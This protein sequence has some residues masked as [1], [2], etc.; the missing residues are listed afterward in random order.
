MLAT[1]VYM[2]VFR[3]VHILAGVLWVGGLGLF[4]LYLQPAAKALGP[5][6]GPFL[7]ELVAKR[8]LPNYLL[9]AGAFTIVAG[10]FLYWHDWQ[11]AASLGDWLDLTV[12]KILTV[13]ALAALIA[14]LMGLLLLKPPV[15]RMM[16]LGGQIAASGG[17]PSPEQGA[18]LQSLQLKSRRLSIAVLALLVFSVLAMSTARY[19]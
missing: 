7:Q 17:P 19:W 12:G 18:E 2:I 5:A 13:G 8:K 1:A 6:A 10:G 9:G 4:V 11:A 3:I 14:W 16:R 15:Q